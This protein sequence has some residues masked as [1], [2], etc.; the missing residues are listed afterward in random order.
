MIIF[1]ILMSRGERATATL[2]TTDP[3]SDAEV[4]W[5]G[6]RLSDLRQWVTQR[7]GMASAPITNPDYVSAC[8]LR[9]ALSAPGGRFSAVRYQIIS[10][11]VEGFPPNWTLP[12][13]PQG[14]M[15]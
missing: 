8:D 3:G 7:G 9:Y 5:Q 4:L 11:T 12:S 10:V 6:D 2:Q 1:S 13:A 14:G 15:Y